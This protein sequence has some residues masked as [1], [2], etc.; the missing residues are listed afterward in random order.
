VAGSGLGAGNASP[1]WWPKQ[2]KIPESNQQVP[3]NAAESA[4]VCGQLSAAHLDRESRLL[5]YSPNIFAGDSKI[6]AQEQLIAD[7]DR[8]ITQIDN[9]IEK[10]QKHSSPR[11][12]RPIG[13]S[14][15]RRL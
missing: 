14:G 2:V 11:I 5:R 10:A 7:L 15:L 3:T 8:Q 4:D 12:S 6:A 13:V 9:A 1:D